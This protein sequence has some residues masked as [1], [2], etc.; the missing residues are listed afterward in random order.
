MKHPESSDSREAGGGD[1]VDAPPTLRRSL[2]TGALGFCLASLC[3]FATVAF[4]ERWMYARLGLYGAYIA[5]TALFILLG[6]G[7]L[8]TLAVGR[9]RL[10]RFYSALRTGLLRV[11][12]RL[13]RRLLHAPRRGGRVGRFARRVRP[14]GLCLRARVRRGALGTEL[15]GRAF[16]SEPIGY[17]LGSALNDAVGGRAG[18]LLWGAAYGLAWAP[19]SGRLCTWRRRAAR[20]NK[21]RTSAVGWEVGWS[22]AN[23]NQNHDLGGRRG[24]R[25]RV[26]RLRA[27]KGRRGWDAAARLAWTVACAAL[28]AHVACAF[29]FYHGWGHDA[30]YLDT[31]RQTNEVFGLDWGGGLY[32][33]YALLTGWVLDVSCW[34]LRGLDSYRRRRGRSWPCGTDF[35]SSSSSTPRSSSRA[36]WRAGRG[37]CVCAGVC[38]AWLARRPRPSDSRRVRGFAL[39]RGG[40]NAMDSLPWGAPPTCSARSALPFYYGWVN[41][42]LAAL[43]MVGTLPGRTQGLGLI[44]EPLFADL[45]IGR[46]AFARI[47]LWATLAGALFCARRRAFDRPLR[48]PRRTHGRGRGARRRSSSG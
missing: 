36:A 46:V 4:A 22:A 1:A 12:R 24:L 25:R 6:G 37:S 34:W 45:Q 14:H 10:P 21:V 29:H 8:G 38:L 48:Q 30:A 11:R 26:G 9:W 47:N 5:W 19:G 35:C 16:R 15:L 41:L 17:F 13:G 40:L 27:L 44:T 20:R 43:A 31:A 28:L 33:N 23:S 39:A 32:I 18:M 3:V 42:A 2:L 7:A